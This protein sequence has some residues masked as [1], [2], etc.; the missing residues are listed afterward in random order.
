MAST[1]PGCLVIRAI[2]GIGDLFGLGM[3]VDG[4]D[5]TEA[6]PHRADGT[7]GSVER[8]ISMLVDDLEA[9]LNSRPRQYALSSKMIPAL[10][11]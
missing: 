10:D 4:V 9:H 8:I 3:K 7:L 11:A 1:P 2:F 6:T 5:A